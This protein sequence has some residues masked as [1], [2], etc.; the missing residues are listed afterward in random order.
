MKIMTIERSYPLIPFI[1][2]VGLIVAC[3]GIP[4]YSPMVR[5]GLAVLSGCAAVLVFVIFDRRLLQ[6]CDDGQK[7]RLLMSDL[8]G[9]IL[10]LLPFAMRA[11]KGSWEN[12]FFDLTCYA[13]CICFCSFGLAA[14]VEPFIRQ[15]ERT[16]RFT[17]ILFPLALATY[18]IVLGWHVIQ[19]YNAYFIE[20]TDFAFEFPPLWQSLRSHPFRMID[21][22]SHETNMLSFH[23]PLIYLP[24]APITFIWDDPRVTLV[25][26]TLFFTATGLTVY[27]L[28]HRHTGS[29]T[30]AAWAGTVFLL[31]LPVHCAHL[32]GLHADPLAMP[33]I[34]LSF[35]FA[36]AKAWKRYWI[37]VGLALICKEYVGL[38]YLGY[39]LYLALNNRRIGIATATVGLT[40]FLFVIKVGIPLFNQGEHPWVMNLNY[41]NIG[42]NEGMLS[43]VLHCFYH[44]GRCAAVL[45]RQHS[46][47]AFVS[48]LLPFCF[49]PAARPLVLAA[50][51][52]IIL[53]NA[54]S[55]SG[56]ELLAHR[57]TL[58]I[59]FVVYALIRFI[60]S[61]SP[62]GRRTFYCLAIMVSVSAT[63][64]AQGHAFPSRGFFAEQGHYRVTGH[65]RA[66]DTLVSMVPPHAPVMASS[67]ITPRLMMRKWYFLFPAFPAPVE[68]EYC[69]VDTLG[70]GELDWNPLQRQRDSLKNIIDKNRYSVIA[71]KSGVFLLRRT[72]RGER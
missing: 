33:F 53:K 12:M 44:P 18:G 27:L 28:A 40:W 38:V 35:Y 57:E 5:C 50:G 69:I 10:F 51:S 25:A 14:R 4:H 34:F 43:M 62:A 30:V 58:F 24:L 2:V 16:R 49:L 41:G 11:E 60:G 59:P 37:M 45:L 67:H 8:F 21:V 63:Y 1:P 46:I 65:Q 54:L 6:R 22:L 23:W 31:Y 66:I 36:E 55:V 48:M 47:V 20:W 56:I 19:Q 26:L 17:A 3:L 15:S 9:T 61:V 42:G 70:Q 13:G 39:G 52:L 32:S 29:R 72:D 64:L 68:P 7:H 71:R